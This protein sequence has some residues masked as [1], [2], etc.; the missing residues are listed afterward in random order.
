MAAIISSALILACL[1]A[2]Q[3]E[4]LDFVLNN[5]DPLETYYYRV[6]LFTVPTSFYF[7]S[8]FVLFPDYQMTVFSSVHFLPIIIVLFVA[9]SI[10]VPIAFSIGAAYCLWLS[11]VLYGLRENR[12]RFEIEFFFFVFFSMLAVSILVL[13]VLVS[14]IENAYFYHFYANGI[15]VGFILVTA[16][17]VIY[18]DLLNELTEVV[19][20]GYSAS[21]LS[22]VDIPEQIKRLEDFMNSDNLYQ[23]ENLSLS[24]LAEVMELTSHQ[25]SELINTQYG[26]GFSKYI[27]ELRVERAKHLLK[28][29]PE[30]SI[31]SIS[32][33][34]GFK[35]QSNFYA[36]FKE[37][38]DMSPGSYRK[39]G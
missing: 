26:V 25:L 33:E 36:A 39:N 31:L 29:E 18:P 12:N 13:G 11:Y 15:A 19:K 2:L 21:T 4:H 6:L 30:A 16:A 27:R 28:A 34:T 23:N 35:S 8:R 24:S 5:S 38:T 10:A 22:N 32:L 7:F 14:F 17:L 37:L 20:L 1:S 9:Q 3:L